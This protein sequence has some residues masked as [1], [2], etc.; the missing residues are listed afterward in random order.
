[1]TEPDP[2]SLPVIPEAIERKI[3]QGKD[4]AIEEIRE[5]AIDQ[6][7]T[8]R[9]TPVH[10]ENLRP[11]SP[12]TAAEMRTQKPGGKL[13]KMPAMRRVIPEPFRRPRID[14]SRHGKEWVWVLA[15]LVVPGDIV[16][17]IGLVDRREE[18]VLYVPRGELVGATGGAEDLV[19]VATGIKI[20]L[21]GVSGASLEFQPDDE[22]HT[23]R[24]Q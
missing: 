20:V 21:H 11:I 6:I 14:A 16:P 18:Q 1:M 10:A 9:T 3:D 2:A 7:R 4:V 5:A 23:F 8:N 17:D 19:P 13:P 15:K 24:K 22:V 12:A